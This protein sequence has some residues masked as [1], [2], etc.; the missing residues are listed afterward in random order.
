MAKLKLLRGTTVQND[1]YTGDQGEVTVD[2]DKDAL[3]VHDNSTA[4]GHEVMKA[5]ASNYDG[6]TIA[7]FK[8]TGITDSASTTALTID[9][10]GNT[11]LAGT[12]NNI[13]TVTSGTFNGTIGSSADLSTLASALLGS[14][15]AVTGGSARV[16][17]LLLQWSG[18][19]YPYTAT[20]STLTFATAYD[21]PPLVLVCLSRL[22][23]WQTGLRDIRIE[24]V[25]ASQVTINFGS[26][27]GD[28]G[29]QYLAIGKKG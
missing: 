13:G 29:V 15:Q 9:A 4:G 14:S 25:S 23:T 10:S 16:G 5:D 11:T 6:S 7:D 17:D 22:Y 18:T 12:A 19:G 2:T 27:S 1:G 21:S 3:R 26:G 24:T 20:S 28:F 8:S